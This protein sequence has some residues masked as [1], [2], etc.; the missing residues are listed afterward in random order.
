MA[1]WVSQEFNKPAQEIAWGS[2]AMLEGFSVDRINKTMTFQV[3]RNKVPLA[4]GGNLGPGAARAVKDGVKIEQ[5]LPEGVSSLEIVR[6]CQ[7]NDEL[8][9]RLQFA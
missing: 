8:I 1:Y 6:Y 2:F 4:F 3:L 5:G 9:L 7:S